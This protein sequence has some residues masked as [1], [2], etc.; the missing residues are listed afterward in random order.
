MVKPFY[1]TSKPF[2]INVHGYSVFTTSSFEII[3]DFEE[4]CSALEAAVGF[5]AALANVRLRRAKL[6]RKF[7][8]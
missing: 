3:Y 1:N 7:V 5:L 2:V 4:K 8:Q 6:Q